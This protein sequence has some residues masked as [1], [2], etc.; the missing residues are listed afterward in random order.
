MLRRLICDLN[1]ASERGQAR[2]EAAAAESRAREAKV[3]G[4]AA[5]APRRTGPQT[6]A[7]AARARAAPE[8]SARETAANTAQAAARERK[9]HRAAQSGTPRERAPTQT[10]TV[11]G[12]ELF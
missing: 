8:E 12:F 6:E 11:A 9:H 3:F 10:T 1:E 2:D 7:P 5:A 4:G